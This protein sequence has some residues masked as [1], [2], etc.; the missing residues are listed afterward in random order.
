MLNIA[1]YLRLSID[2][3]NEESLSISNQRNLIQMFIDQHG[4]NGIIKE[5]IDDGYSGTTTNR[6]GFQRMLKEVRNGRISC[7]IVK[8][9]SRFMRNYI[10]AGD[11]LENIFPFLGIRFISVN[12]NYDSDLYKDS[13]SSIDVQ[14]KN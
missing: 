4:F 1:M 3:E 7:I 6:P 11:Y 8:D 12:D 13:G 9:L 2:E 5:F 14:F 10:E